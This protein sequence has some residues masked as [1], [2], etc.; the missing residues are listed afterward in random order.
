MKAM[1]H[2]TPRKPTGRSD[3]NKNA[4][5]AVSP[6]AIHENANSNTITANGMAQKKVQLECNSEMLSFVTRINRHM[7]TIKI[8]ILTPNKDLQ[9]AIID[10][11]R[12]TLS[13]DGNEKY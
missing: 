1:P 4:L 11:T 13:S 3:V 9:N 6:G 7:P 2:N 5:N 10:F 12:L 8:A